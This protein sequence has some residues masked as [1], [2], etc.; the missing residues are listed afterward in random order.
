[1]GTE[2]VEII[3]YIED[4][5]KIK[6]STRY[7]YKTESYEIIAKLIMANEVISEDSIE[8]ESI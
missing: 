2:A 4:N 7:N 8:F 1:M 5:L 6:L 3:R